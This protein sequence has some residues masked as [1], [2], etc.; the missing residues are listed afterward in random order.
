M[1]AV[2][3]PNTR[4]PDV[5]LV[6]DDT[7]EVFD[8]VQGLLESTDCV[9]HATSSPVEGVRSYETPWRGIKL[10]LLDSFS[11]TLR[12]DEVVEYLQRMNPTVRVVMISGRRGH[13]TEE[14]SGGRLRGFL[15][16]SLA[17]DAVP[18]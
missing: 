11:Q 3:A 4:R 5:V 18:G 2:D 14:M 1:N 13:A 17:P 6:I 12:D 10:L 16:K 7:S 9:V 15:Q 8:G